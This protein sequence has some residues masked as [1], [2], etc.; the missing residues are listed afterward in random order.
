MNG[1]TKE[2][3]MSEHAPIST[4]PLAPADFENSAASIETDSRER[5]DRQWTTFLLVAVGTFMT[6]LDSSIVNISL[7]SIART[8]NAS[9][10][11]AVEWVIIAY[12]VTIATTL[13]TFGRLSDMVGRKPVWLAGLALFS[14]GSGM[15][16]AATSLHLLIAARAFQGIGGALLFSASVAIITD[17]FPAHQRGFALGCNAVVIALGSSVG[18]VLGGLITSHWNW[19]WIFYIN[20]P[21]GL[22]GLIGSMRVLRRAIGTR[23]QGFDPLGAAIIALS[24]GPLT[25][26]LSFLQEW[27]W[28]SW[29]SLLCLGASALALISVPAVERRV[30]NPIIDLRLLANRVFASALLSMT[31]A[32]L[33]LFSVGFMM[34]FYFEELRG[35]S[36]ARSG[37]FLTVFPLTIAL[38]APASGLLA[39]HFGSRWLASG[40]LAIACAG[41]V[42][43][44]QLGDRSPVWAIIGPLA[45]LGTGQGLFTTPNARALM[46][47][48]PL[49]EQGESS[50]LL[51]TGRVLGQSLSVALAGA[52]FTGFSGAQAGPVVRATGFHDGAADQI[53]VAP[54]GFLAG[55]HTALLV[56]A[57]IAAVGALAALTRGS[58]GNGFDPKRKTFEP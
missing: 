14:L 2:I 42:L 3:A 28:R 16:G 48:A 15:C 10:G 23:A 27:G 34:P 40:G 36:V 53:A 25:L 24:F 7:P 56:C 6:M 32:M 45:I 47:A 20:L 12:L 5:S 54:I 43:L 52:I 35:F 41:L 46:N 57:G 58:E 30:L 8:F 13:L 55:F 37:L 11:G 33:A 38:V 51:A 4:A 1:R 17:T 26:A 22:C 39:D 44:A 31:L 18:P 49:G 21:I 19:R 9:V 29:Q 50:G